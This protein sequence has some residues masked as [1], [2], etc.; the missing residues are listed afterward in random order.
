[1]LPLQKFQLDHLKKTLEYFVL[2]GSRI[3]CRDQIRQA[4]KAHSVL[5]GGEAANMVKVSFQFNRIQ[6][7]DRASLETPW[8]AAINT[9]LLYRIAGLLVGTAVC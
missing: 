2:E 7:T 6:C 9:A 8:K 4:R 5:S 3:F 1:M